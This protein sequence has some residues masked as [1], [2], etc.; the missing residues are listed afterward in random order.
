MLAN[1]IVILVQEMLVSENDL[2]ESFASRN[3][4]ANPLVARLHL[5]IANVNHLCYC[6]G[7]YN[8]RCFGCWLCFATR[9]GNG[10]PFCNFTT[11]EF[12]L[13]DKFCHISRNNFCRM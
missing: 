4:R 2:L 9:N 3:C 13:A 10:S 6:L 8:R 11:H 1:W 7:F 5:P 12:S